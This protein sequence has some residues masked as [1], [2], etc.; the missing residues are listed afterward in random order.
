MHTE[1]LMS[2]MARQG[3]RRLMAEVERRH[4][5]IRTVLP[6][7][8]AGRLRRAAGSAISRLGERV[9]GFPPAAA[10]S[11]VEMEG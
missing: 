4:R 8:G 1:M 3:H 9:A 11:M 6:A 7:A 2:E 5:E 10:P